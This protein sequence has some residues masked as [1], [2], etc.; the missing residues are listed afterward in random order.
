MCLLVEAGGEQWLADTGFGTTLLEA[1]PVR[2]GAI[3][4]QGKWTY[5]LDVDDRDVWL[6]RSKTS[7][8]WATEY[9]FSLEPQRPIDYVVHNHYTSTYPGSPFVNQLVALRKTPEQQYA[10]RGRELT[11]SAPG[12]ASTCQT[13]SDDDLAGVLEETFGIA[14]STAEVAK[15]TGS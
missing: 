15:L 8:G 14:L 6:L 5:R 10:L 11:T 1:A 12:Q 13:V 9:A 7:D 2:D 3:S 4:E